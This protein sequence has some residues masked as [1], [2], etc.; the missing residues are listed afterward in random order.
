[1]SLNM[2][3]AKTMNEAKVLVLEVLNSRENGILS[4][5]QEMEEKI[6]SLLDDQ[7][8]YAALFKGDDLKGWYKPMSEWK[9]AKFDEALKKWRSKK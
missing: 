3:T 5:D 8:I 6:S 2:K 7:E 1:M 9:K 4:T